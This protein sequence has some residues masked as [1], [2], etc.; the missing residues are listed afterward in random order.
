MSNPKVSFKKIAPLIL[1]IQLGCL[2]F[3]G[4]LALNLE[5]DN[6]IER[7]S[8]EKHE[9][10][11]NFQLFQA[12]FATRETFLIT[13]CF[14][15]DAVSDLVLVGEPI[16]DRI[17]RE[18]GIV[19]RRSLQTTIPF[20][21]YMSEEQLPFPFI[22]R[23]RGLYT[24]LF[25]ING[26]RESLFQNLPDLIQELEQTHAA[27]LA[28]VVVAGEP[29]VNHQLNQSALEVRNKFFPILVVCTLLLLSFLFRSVKVLFVVGLSVGTGLAMTMGTMALMGQTLD[30]VTTLIP[31]L[32]FVLAIAM[33]MHVLI[34]IG[35]HGS[36]LEGIRH[37][38]GP[39]FWVALTTSIG[40]ASLM[41]SYVSPIAAM[42][43]FMAIGIWLIFVWTHV[44]HLGISLLIRLEIE[45]PKLRLLDRL[46]RSRPYWWCLRRPWL[47]FSAVLIII[48]GALLLSQNPKESNGLN[49]F[50]AKH[51]IREATEFLEQNVTGASHLELLIKRNG[52]SRNDETYTPDW[53]K[54]EKLEDDLSR[55]PHVRHIF[56]INQFV[57]TLT[58]TPGL[59]G[60]A[61]TDPD[62]ALSV[63]LRT[64]RDL[65]APYLSSDY[66]RI[67]MLVDSL[68][69]EAYEGLKH[70]L[71]ELTER[72]GLN[73]E[74]VLTG[75]LDRI[76][77]IQ[78]YLLNS[79]ST[80]LGLTIV[81]IMVL[82]I[83]ILGRRGRF[84]I[85]L[86]PNLLPLGMMG[87]AMALFQ[88][89]T[90]ISTVMVFSIA[91][92]IAVDD[93]IHLLHTYYHAARDCR[94]RQR[95]R[96][97]LSQDVRAILLTSV[98]L[99]FGFAVLILS[100]FIPTADFGKLMAVGMAFA[101]VGDAFYLPILLRTVAKTYQN[102]KRSQ[103]KK[104][105]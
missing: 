39:N 4:R 48:A 38:L 72:S 19:G 67:Q 5:F 105:P 47:V 35:I 3:F 50:H 59:P 27:I 29:I 40:F 33:Q 25:E 84:R 93:T 6:R 70:Q 16:F 56:S 94:F 73:R 82:M 7:F 91:F 43:K 44:T 20:Q 57:K 21:G 96:Y 104:N 77:E 62:Q 66:Y 15:A 34:S 2:F 53:S 80:S 76:I 28:R 9:A 101:F 24:A 90:T 41:T 13:L 55:L 18:P 89:K 102:E 11:R 60:F 61:I 63:M 17:A 87:L 52:E 1:L 65:I 98:V 26:D 32:I 30:L 83:L 71:K 75:T 99:T 88:I 97:T 64:R 92:G 103:K 49:Y 37:K 31:A 54:I 86:I 42:G 69:S 100:Y 81:S 78:S 10:E 51:P 79:L 22:D 12:E 85:I 14:K 36:V 74:M 68:D 46:I 8:V 95:W 58:E 23:E 45:P